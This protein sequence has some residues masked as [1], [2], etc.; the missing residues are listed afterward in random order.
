MAAC[1]CLGPPSLVGFDVL[2]SWLVIRPLAISDRPDV[3]TFV[4]AVLLASF[5]FDARMCIAVPIPSLHSPVTVTTS[6]KQNDKQ[7]ENERRAQPR[8]KLYGGV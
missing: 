3:L 7:N 2:T 5:F 6:S 4:G 8:R 1:I